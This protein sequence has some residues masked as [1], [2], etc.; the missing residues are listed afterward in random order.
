MVVVYSHTFLYMVACIVVCVQYNASDWLTGLSWSGQPR[1]EEENAFF[2]SSRPLSHTF[3]ILPSSV[4]TFSSF[5]P[6]SRREKEKKKFCCTP[7]WFF[8]F[9]KYRLASFCVRYVYAPRPPTSL[10][11]WGDTVN[12]FAAAAVAVWR[13]YEVGLKS[14]VV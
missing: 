11:F 13:T 14:R 4:L 8:S 2:P 10:L 12:K 1:E 7:K 9:G 5:P 6:F 3:P